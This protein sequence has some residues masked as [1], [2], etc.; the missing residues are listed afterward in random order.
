MGGRSIFGEGEWLHCVSW[1][2]WMPCC[3]TPKVVSSLHCF[4]LHPQGI[5]PPSDGE[6]VQEG[7]FSTSEDGLDLLL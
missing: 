6:R 5:K 3:Q 2:F 4:L 7:L 1:A